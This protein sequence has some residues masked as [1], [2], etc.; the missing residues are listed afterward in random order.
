MCETVAITFRDAGEN[1][2]GMQKVGSIEDSGFTRE[3]LIRAK[4]FFEDRCCKC[5][6]VDGKL[7]DCVMCSS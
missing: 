2:V 4:K 5:E 6:W 1:H 3:D 7:E